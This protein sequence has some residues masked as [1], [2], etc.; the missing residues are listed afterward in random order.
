M[1]PTLRP[2]SRLLTAF[3]RSGKFT[4]HHLLEKKAKV[5]LA[6]RDL[7]KAHATIA[8]I[9]KT[10]PDAAVEALQLDLSSFASVKAAAETFQSAESDLHI[11]VNNAGTVG[12]P[13]SLTADGYD[14][15]WSVGRPSS[16]L[17]AVNERR[18]QTIWD[19]TYLLGYLCRH[20]A[21]P[22]RRR[23]T[24]CVSSMSAQ[25]RTPWVRRVGL[26]LTTSTRRVPA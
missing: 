1:C 20:F 6:A 9:K 17:T 3:S 16:C 24:P 25:T 10:L 4:V 21:G 7:S 5:Y 2:N 18:R 11:L 14:V 13:F 22:L 19:T 15:Q 23:K 26:C 12:L 8:E